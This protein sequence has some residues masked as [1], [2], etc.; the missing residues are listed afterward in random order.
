MEEYTKEKWTATGYSFGWAVETL[1]HQICGL[2]PG[3]AASVALSAETHE[4]NAHLIAQSP[5]MYE[6]I[7]A[8]ITEIEDGS[9][10]HAHLILTESIRELEV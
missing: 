5:K 3:K 4:A 6:A 1:T 9:A 2:E 8:A 7:K 10:N